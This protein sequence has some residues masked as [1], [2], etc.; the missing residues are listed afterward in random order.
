MALDA[1][2]HYEIYETMIVKILPKRLFYK[3]VDAA[4]SITQRLT[5]A[6]TI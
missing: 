2:P 6:T 3:L 4:E 5:A 1:V